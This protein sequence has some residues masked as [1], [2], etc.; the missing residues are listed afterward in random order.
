MSGPIHLPV[1]SEPEPGVVPDLHAYDRV[2]VSSSGGKDSQAMLDYVVE[3]AERFGYA[4][5][6]IVVVHA[7][8]GRVEWKGTRGLAE[9]QARH[10]GLRFEVVSRIGGTS[11]GGRTADAPY[12]KGERFGDLLDHVERRKRWPGPGRAR[13]C[14]SD[15]KRGPIRALITRL[16]R[17]HGERAPFRL[18]SCMGLRAEESPNREK[19][20][21]LVAGAAP[22]KASREC[23]TK[24]QHVD[25]WLP[26]HLWTEVQ[27]WDRIRRSR[28][29][30]HPAYD[31]G[32]PRL[33]CVFCVFAPRA[34]LLIAGRH[35]PELLD[36]Y[37]RVEREINHT[38]RHGFAIADV[39]AALDAGADVDTRELHGAWGM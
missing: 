30:H 16:H 34:A 37:V 38:F 15:H 33:S 36:E 13:Y 35:N 18:L 20:A 4:R 22:G 19:M 25:T 1:L 12:A 32:M 9:A 17:E 21:Q 8:L 39:K 23:L 5:E 14:T 11:P 26:I 3:L 27:V 31:A 29:P 10:Y 7:D 24:T 6:R 28:V 2:L